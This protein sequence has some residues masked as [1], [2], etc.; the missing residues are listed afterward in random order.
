MKKVES[1][2]STEDFKMNY[3]SRFECESGEVARA[4][5]LEVTV[6]YKKAFYRKRKVMNRLSMSLDDIH[7][8]A[9]EYFLY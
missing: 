9:D 6:L 4:A 5:R 1:C 3:H 7:T 2:R 8:H